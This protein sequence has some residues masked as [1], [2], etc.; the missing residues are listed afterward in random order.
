MTYLV[1]SH[2]AWGTTVAGE[3]QSLEQAKAL[4]NSL[5]T[6]RWFVSDGSIKGLSIVDT[7]VEGGSTLDQFSFHQG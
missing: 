2:D 5:K 4:F 7:S 6:D 1:K 3:F